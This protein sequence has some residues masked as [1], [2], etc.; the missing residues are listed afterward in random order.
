[1]A[2]VSTAAWFQMEAE[3]TPQTA[4][5]SGSAD[6]DIQ[7]VKGHKV[8]QKLTASGDI[9]YTNNTV[10]EKEANNDTYRNT[11]NED[12]EKDDHN[13][14]I[15][16][17]G[18]G[19]YLSWKNTKDSFKYTRT[20]DGQGNVTSRNYQKFT[21]LEKGTKMYVTASF[22]ANQFF[23][24]RR[25]TNENNETVNAAVTITS[26]SPS[27]LASTDN[28]DVKVL[29][30][31]TYTVWMNTSNPTSVILETTT[32]NAKNN[33]SSNPMLPKGKS[34]PTVKN[35]NSN[36][37]VVYFDLGSEWDGMGTPQMKIGEGSWGDMT[38][39]TPKQKWKKTYT[40][41]TNQTTL[42]LYF[43]QWG[44][45]YWHPWNGSKDT[46]N[47]VISLSAVSNKLMPGF[48]YTVHYTSY[49]DAQGNDKWFNYSIERHPNSASATTNRIYLYDKNGGSS[50]YGD[51]PWA[52]S[53]DNDGDYTRTNNFPGVRMTKVTD[54]LYYVDVSVSYDRI[55]F[56]NGSNSAQSN[57]IT[58][59]TNGDNLWT[60]TGVKSGNWSVTASE[61]IYLYDP[62]S[63][64][65]VVKAYIR[66]ST[67]GTYPVAFPGANMT[68]DSTLFSDDSPDVPS[69]LFKITVGVGFDKIKFNNKPTSNAEGAESAEFTASDYDGKVFIVTGIS[70][71]TI[72]G[73]WSIGV[74]CFY[75]ETHQDLDYWGAITI[76]DAANVV[77]I[78]DIS[79]FR[80]TSRFYKIYFRKNYI[81]RFRKKDISTNE[82]HMWTDENNKLDLNTRTTN[83]I[84]INADGSNQNRTITQC[85]AK[86][87]SVGTAKIYVNN[88]DTATM[89]LGDVDNNN[90]FIYEEGVSVTHGDIVDV[91]VS[92]VNAKYTNLDA[93]TYKYDDL[94]NVSYFGGDPSPYLV[95]DDDEIKVDLG[96]AGKTCRLNF[97][98]V[99]TKDGATQKKATI[100][101]VMVPELGNGFYIMPSTSTADIKYWNNGVKTTQ[102]NYQNVFGFVGA[103]KMQSSSTSS[104]SYGGYYSS[105]NGEKL[106]FRSYNNAVD[107]LY[108]NF[109]I[110]ACSD[111]ITATT[112]TF[113]DKTY[114][115]LT[116]N[117]PGYYNIEI[118]GSRVVVT[119]F[120]FDNFFALNRLD[121]NVISNSSTQATIVSKKTA[122]VLEVAFKAVAINSFDTRITLDIDLPTNLKNYV[123]VAFF[124]P[125]QQAI[126]NDTGHQTFEEDTGALLD[127]YNY[128]QT[129]YENATYMKQNVSSITSSTTILAN[130]DIDILYHAYIL[131]DY[132]AGSS[133]GSMP[134]NTN[135]VFYFHIRTEQIT[136]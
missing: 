100:A 63:Y 48:E 37:I 28:G 23:R 99:N 102:S 67:V 55:I 103:R 97:Y 66:H 7:S 16:D 17:L 14:D 69:R 39:V 126:A 135:E 79:N 51:P 33:S 71:S 106:F 27:Q 29:I 127:P 68:Q 35:A 6:I 82:P 83:Y 98:V 60:A 132:M 84:Y 114:G 52:D 25:Y 31:G 54:Y 91:R 85:V 3:Q 107:T 32:S 131:I 88:V 96:E 8:V 53:W 26:A 134:A 38:N 89:A 49:R 115:Y 92:N 133:F 113:G 101:I 9:D 74:D 81:I 105:G 93:K 30:A 123:G 128:M 118:A 110:T 61:N 22:T 78:D 120:S 94:Y 65:T 119:P 121:T 111:K 41:T 130:A 86:H 34:G 58:L 50:Y 124:I 18:D 80:L 116:F 40:A 43:Q 1:M 42:N 24:I 21:A 90:Y 57:D 44:S 104:A 108:T 4:M 125:T 72:N 112:N 129:Y 46:N 56:S 77:M 59:P 13:Y 15:P 64:L 117:S 19:Y 20:K 122:L 73:V 12:L 2:A 136:A 5:V 36:E 109:N 45:D 70:G 95:E 87:S 62:N 47:S 76:V 10:T 11:T 75:L